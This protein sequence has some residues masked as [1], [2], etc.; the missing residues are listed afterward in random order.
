[1]K[2]TNTGDWKFEPLRKLI[3][4]LN[5]PILIEGL[6]GIGNVGKVAAD[7]IID[8]VDAKPLFNLFSHDLPNSVFVNEKNLV[9][10]PTIEIYFRKFN[11]PKKSDL[12]ILTGDVQPTEEKSSYSF[13]ESVLDV[14]EKFGVKEIITL[15]GNRSCR[16][17]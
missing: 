13:S 4:V 11:N 3:P 9:E 15:G 2:I 17:S 12:L 1:M 16:C 8:E 5:N 7:F 14:A 10:L 6:P